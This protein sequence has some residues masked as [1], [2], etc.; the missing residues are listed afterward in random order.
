MRWQLFQ[1]SEEGS[2][3]RTG[4]GTDT[5]VPVDFSR[6]YEIRCS[7]KAGVATCLPFCSWPSGKDSE[8][9]G[10]SDVLLS[11]LLSFYPRWMT[12]PGVLLEE[13]PRGP[14]G[15]VAEVQP[16]GRPFLLNVIVFLILITFIFVVWLECAR[17]Y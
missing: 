15:T 2:G 17:F 14:P 8:P 13:L 12:R 5:L 10:E 6:V 4:D 9:Q 16:A 11:S 7:Q 3:T 1:G